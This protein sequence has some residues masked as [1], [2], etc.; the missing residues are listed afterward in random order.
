MPDYEFLELYLFRTIPRGDVKPLAKALIARFGAL[1]ASLDD[2]KT[3]CGVGDA[4]A[5]T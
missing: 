3:V 4:V 1:R 2:L 5:L